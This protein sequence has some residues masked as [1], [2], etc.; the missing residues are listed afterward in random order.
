MTKIKPPAGLWR[1]V[2]HI[3]QT[4]NYTFFLKLAPQMPLFFFWKNDFDLMDHH[5]RVATEGLFAPPPLAVPN[6][7]GYLPIIILS[8]FPEVTMN[9][10]GTLAIIAFFLFPGQYEHH[11]SWKK[12]LFSKVIKIMTP[13]LA[14][15]STFRLV[16][17]QK[18][19]NDP[20]PTQPLFWGPFEAQNWDFRPIF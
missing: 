20:P 5:R 16:Y 3:Y 12:L 14:N 4:Q 13:N 18:F 7:L 11:Q 17:F 6:Q 1:S 19:K 10:V 15:I 9:Q 8:N 2:R